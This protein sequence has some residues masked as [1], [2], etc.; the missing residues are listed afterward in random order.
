MVGV[1]PN[2]VITVPNKNSSKKK[3]K[4]VPNKKKMG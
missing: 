4:T 1:E 2:I 3:K